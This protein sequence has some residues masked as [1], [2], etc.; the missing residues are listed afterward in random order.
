MTDIASDGRQL[1]QVSAAVL[2][3]GGTSAGAFILSYN[4]PTV[5][6]GCR[7]GG[8]MIFIVVALVLLIAEIL[9]WWL[10]SPLRKHDRFYSS[11]EAYSLHLANGHHLR[12]K[13][14][15]LPGLATSKFILSY[16]LRKIEAAVLQFAL[17]MM[18]LLPVQHK[19]QQLE[20]TQHSIR[21]H[22]A[23]LQNLTTRN[24]LQRCFFTPLECANM[25][26]ACYLIFAQTIGAFNNC[27][28]MTSSWGGFGGYLDFTQFNVADSPVVLKYWIQGTV[29]TCVVMGL[30]M[31]YI[32]LE[33]R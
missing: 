29:V 33:V 21:E 30:G 2:L 3:V 14:T 28:C 23:T 8:Y 19:K 22:F 4:T 26:W 18:R 27:A 16:V 25:T 6:L 10:T 15:S 13:H 31:G 5:G 24:W 12:P 20:A 9:T 32:V 1:W 11:V 17:F 7:T